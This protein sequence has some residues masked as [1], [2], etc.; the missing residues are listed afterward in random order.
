MYMS[1][2]STLNSKRRDDIHKYV[3][4][5][6][7]TLYSAWKRKTV[8][9]LKTEIVSKVREVGHLLFPDWISRADA[10]RMVW[11]FDPTNHRYDKIQLQTMARA[12]RIHVT[13][14]TRG[15]L[16]SQIQRNIRHVEIED[17][18]DIDEDGGEH[19]H[20]IFQHNSMFILQQQ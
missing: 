20:K 14:R 8:R 10:G 7:I 11:N 12:L 15:D 4:V 17:E 1:L 5:L 6:G 18:D 3:K 19:Q 13:E 16:I 2:Q 9:V